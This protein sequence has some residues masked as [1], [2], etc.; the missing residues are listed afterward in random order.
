MNFRERFRRSPEGS[1]PE[2][3]GDAR[4][5]VRYIQQNFPQH[6]LAIDHLATLLAERQN[7]LV[8]I[9]LPTVSSLFDFV[10]DKR[11][12]IDVDGKFKISE[13]D[14]PKY[15]QRYLK[16][17]HSRGLMTTDVKATVDQA[18]FVLIHPSKRRNRWASIAHHNFT[19]Y[20]GDMFGPGWAEPRYRM[21]SDNPQGYDI[22]FRIAT[23]Y[24]P[25]EILSR[26]CS[27]TGNSS[28][29]VRMSLG[30]QQMDFSIDNQQRRSRTV[31]VPV[32]VKEWGGDDIRDG[33]WQKGWEIFGIAGGVRLSEIEAPR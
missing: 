13:E 23:G 17:I 26:Y 7:P 31:Y 15:L 21:F 22:G 27:E 30:P 2:S 32:R 19:T 6:S 3:H 10:K 5:L 25:D 28:S 8:Y 33:V 9:H 18:F 4:Q 20:R 11:A 12:F 24:D 1:M 29:I 16:R 14:S